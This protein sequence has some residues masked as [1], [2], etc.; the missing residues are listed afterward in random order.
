M[1]WIRRTPLPIAILLL[2]VYGG[3][4]VCTSLHS[5]A[6]FP[7]PAKVAS[8][9]KQRILT[10][11]K[12]CLICDFLFK[13]VPQNREKPCVVHIQ[14]FLSFVFPQ[15]EYAIILGLSTLIFQKTGRAP[16]AFA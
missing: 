8:T 12:H 13:K 11:E 15:G 2:L 4:Q 14:L 16:P 7:L 3:V 5:H 1:P 10:A 9:G 6:R